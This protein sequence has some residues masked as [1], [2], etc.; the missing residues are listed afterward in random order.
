MFQ[1][2]AHNFIQIILMSGFI[3]VESGLI[4]ICLKQL[5]SFDIRKQSFTTKLYCST[6]RTAYCKYKSNIISKHTNTQ[7]LVQCI[8]IQYR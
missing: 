4:N 6:I 2:N 8:R 7:N 3:D 5:K 1:L